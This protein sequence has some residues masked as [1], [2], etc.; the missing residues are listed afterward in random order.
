[1][2]KIAF[3]S[4][5]KKAEVIILMINGREICYKYEELK[6]VI[7]KYVFN[8]DTIWEDSRA[9]PDTNVGIGLDTKK[10]HF[11]TTKLNKLIENDFSFLKN[12]VWN[13]LDKSI[14]E[15]G[16]TED[17]IVYRKTHITGVAMLS[18]VILGRYKRTLT[19][20]EFKIMNYQKSMLNTIFKNDLDWIVELL[21]YMHD[22]YKLTKTPLSHGKMAAMY[23]S[24]VC[25]H[26]G[27]SR[28][29]SIVSDMKAALEFHTYDDIKLHNIFYEILY[30]ADILSKWSMPYILLK[31][32]ML[33][34]SPEEIIELLPQREEYFSPF[35]PELVK[36]LRKNLMNDLR[37]KENLI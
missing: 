26:Y 10:E 36:E 21:A 11:L 23:L 19:T 9:F 14:T 30:E 4:K 15:K 28:Q 5:D 7:D 32:D 1:M 3:L 12:F 25:K 37:R 16:I 20:G 22:M 34:I 8:E 24:D 35:Y 31:S 29:D 6:T 2:E 33:K 13:L 27:I 17:L 18:R